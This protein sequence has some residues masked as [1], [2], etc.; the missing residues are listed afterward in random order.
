M[1][2]VKTENRGGLQGSELLHTYIPVT[3]LNE[4]FSRVSTLVPR[5]SNPSPSAMSYKLQ[6]FVHSQSLFLISAVNLYITQ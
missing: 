3:Y 1:I 5:G 2:N 4:Y 6:F